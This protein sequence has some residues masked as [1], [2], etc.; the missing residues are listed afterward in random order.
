MPT[1]PT[2]HADLQKRAYQQGYDAGFYD[3][4]IH[5]YD[6]EAPYRVAY[7]NGHE[8]GAR[9]RRIAQAPRGRHAN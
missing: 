1:D 2:T 3:R 8:A 4:E 9:D 5:A 7:L 6:W